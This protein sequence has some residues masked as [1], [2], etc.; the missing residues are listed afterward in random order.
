[1]TENIKK[2]IEEKLTIIKLPNKKKLIEEEIIEGISYKDG[3]IQISLFANKDNI[4]EIEIVGK[5]I[6]KELQNI[7]GVI[8][9]TTVLTNEP[10]KRETKEDKKQKIQ[11]INNVKKIIAIAS[12]K[13]GVGK[14]T[15]S[16]N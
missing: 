7:E 16:I 10:N 8:S 4:E 1:M 14:S 9:V 5:L 12:G 3:H 11:Q 15:I 13:G 6:K 2:I